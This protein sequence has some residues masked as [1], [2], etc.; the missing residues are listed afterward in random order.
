MRPSFFRTAPLIAFGL[1]GGCQVVLGIEPDLRLATCEEGE[2]YN[3]TPA[4]CNCAT[5]FCVE[6]ICWDPGFGG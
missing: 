3:A 6:G 2:V 5:N 1:L 4:D